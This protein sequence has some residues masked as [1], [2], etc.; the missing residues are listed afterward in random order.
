MGPAALAVRLPGAAPAASWFSLHACSG[1]WAVSVWADSEP[2]PQDPRTSP[3]CE[4]RRGGPAGWTW[5]PRTN[6]P[7]TW[8]Q[9]QCYAGWTLTSSGPGPV[10][11][12]SRTQVG[13]PRTA[14]GRRRFDH[15]SPHSAARS[16]SARHMPNGASPSRPLRLDSDNWRARSPE[17]NPRC[18]R[19]RPALAWQLLGK[20]PP[21]RETRT[22]APPLGHSSLQVDLSADR[23]RWRYACLRPPR[24]P[25]RVQ[26][27]RPPRAVGPR[28]GT[29]ADQELQLFQLGNG[30]VGPAHQNRPVRHE[31]TDT[32]SVT[33]TWPVGC[34][35]LLATGTVDVF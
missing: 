18:Q 30:K 5:S 8:C 11:K 9:E 20:E 21:G 23:S 14:S 12:G 3:S 6:L 32:D 1:S 25:H 31:T 35:Q 24:Q 4:R 26:W 17:S 15:V 2:R 13:K 29:R 28:P 19:K 22:S 10:E 27:F 7:I 33:Q 34:K 16:S